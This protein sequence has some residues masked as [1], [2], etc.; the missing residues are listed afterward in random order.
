MSK[1]DQLAPHAAA[2][3]AEDAAD[4]RR[5]RRPARLGLAV[6]VLFLGVAFGWGGFVP[7]DSAAV[8]PGFVS[9]DTN[10]KTI[11][12]LEG[13][14]VR[15]ILVRE[16]DRVTAGQALIR[17]ED[18]GPRAKIE[19]L[20]AQIASDSAQLRLVR[21]EEK[22]VAALLERGLTQ[23]PRL[24]QLQRRAAELEGSITQSQAQLQ[25]A[26]DALERTTIRAPIA[27]TVVELRVHSLR[28]VIAPGAPVLD[29]VP[30]DEPL[31]IEARI[32]PNDIDVVHAN[33]P[34]NIR[35][36]PYNFRTAVLVRGIVAFV[37]A[38]RI[39]DPKTNQVYYSARIKIDR[40]ANKDIKLPQ[41]YPGMPV[42]VMIVTGQ[43]TAL[44]YLVAPLTASFNRAF[45]Q[46]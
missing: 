37:S 17:L 23:R 24:L 44:S 16:G 11:Q 4:L 32:D 19:Q 35:L 26:R 34:A 12:H 14:I 30:S 39:T 3:P 10:R 28:G 46:E 6:V 22:T 15:E 5:I 9:I 36:T 2:L 43:R 20:E 41:L 45:R 21:E 38:D 33:L 1:S 25:A 29:I 18:T 8:A 27:G 40:D 7:L 13:G 31:V 42:E